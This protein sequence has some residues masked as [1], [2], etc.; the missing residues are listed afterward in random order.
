YNELRDRD[1]ILGEINYGSFRMIVVK[2]QALGGKAGVR[3]LAASVQDDFNIIPINGYVLDT[4]NPDATY[5][6]LPADLRKTDIADALARGTEPAGGLY[7]IQFAGPIQDAWLD[8]L[9][10]TGVEVITYMPSNA[11]VVR[12]NRKAAAAL[13]RFAKQ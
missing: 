7:I 6:Q 10:A 12:G 9:K 1:A 5:S 3:A 8:A 4:T 2:E 13:L 11:Y